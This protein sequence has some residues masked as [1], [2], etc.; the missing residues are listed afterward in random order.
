ML[1][2]AG[3]H[4]GIVGSGVAQCLED[5][6]GLEGTGARLLVVDQRIAALPRTQLGS[7]RRQPLARIG[8][9]QRPRNS[10]RPGYRVAG[11]SP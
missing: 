6:L 8:G 1:T 3:G 4:D 11:C 9:G 5:E 2:D 10:R 7:P